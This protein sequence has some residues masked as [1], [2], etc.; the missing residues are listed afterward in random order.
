MAK[1]QQL[2]PL[3]Q[4]NEILFGHD[5][6]PGA[7]AYEIDGAA[8]VKIFFRDSD[9]LRTE[10]ANLRPFMLL[11]SDEPLSGWKGE[12]QIEIL[13]GGGAFNR[14]AL[15]SDLKQLDDARFYL[16]K[17][18]GK[19]PSVGDAPYWY[20]SDPLHQFLLLSGRTH[21]LG[22]TFRELKR[23]QI[24][25]E[26]YCQNGFIF[27]MRRGKAIA[28]PLLPYAIPPGG[29]GL[30]RARNTAKRRCSTNS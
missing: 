5:V 26:T 28:L 27:P 18:T 14:L 16:Q 19:T 29:S 17:K 20:F 11:Q 22:M 2:L 7:I 9:T 24:D 15:F 13:A 25:V 12:A 1:P 10:T 21:F 8:G 4:E 3:F 23:L 6:T 30:S